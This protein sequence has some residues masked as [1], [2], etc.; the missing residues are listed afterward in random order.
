MRH[1]AAILFICSTALCFSQSRITV[2]RTDAPFHIDG[3]MDEAA[4][5]NAA[6]IADFIQRVPNSGEPMSERTEVYVTF[7]RDQLYFGLRC[8]DAQP[9][10][11]IAKQLA[12]DASLDYDDKI[13]III[14]TFLDRRSGYW[15]QIN[16][17]GCIGD[18][19][20]SQNG[21]AFNKSWDGL[22]EGAAHITA[23]GWEGEIAIPFKTMSFRKGQS[24][25]G[26][27]LIRQVSRK[28]EQGYWPVANLNSHKF[29]VSDAGL[30]DGLLDISQGIGLDAVPYAL[31][32][33]DARQGYERDYP[34]DIGLDAFYQIT[35]GLKSALT[36]NTDFAQTE[37]DDQRINL[38]RFPLFFEEKRDFFLDG[39]NYF[40]YGIDGERDHPYQTSLMPFFSRRLGLDDDGE[41]VPIIAGLKLTGQAGAWN[42]GLLDIVED[43]DGRASNA[44]VGRIARHIGGQ[45]YIGAIGT[46]RNSFTQAGNSLFGLDAKLATS[47]FLGDKNISLTL[48]GL[49]SD[50]D[51]S[52]GR[53]H[54]YGVS[55]IYPNDFIWIVTGWH[56]IGENF[57]AGLGFVPRHGI[58]RGYFRGGIGPRPGKWGILQ[59]ITG[60]H[61]NHV[62]DLRNV[63]LT[64]EAG[65]MPFSIEFLSGEHVE[66]SFY[67]TC[68][69]LREDFPIHPDHTIPVGDYQFWRSTLQGTTA[70][71][72]PFYFSAL[73]EAGGF[74]D[75]ARTQM[76]T[77][78]S[79]KV[80]VP[81]LVSM[82]YEHND[83]SLPSG[84][85]STD[86]GRLSVNVLFSP[87]VFLYNFIQYDNLSK[88]LG[89]QSRFVWI[90]KPGRE[91]FLVWK[92]I[93]QNP[94]DRFAMTESATRLKFK[95]TIRF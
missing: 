23:W 22:W 87:D 51:D 34:S 64:R 80:G 54:A 60:I 9:K 77:E 76:Q 92:S 53:D 71:R 66:F 63:L 16:P 41:L 28:S 2:P 57:N 25:W 75:G 48:H 50:T 81:L 12:R 27:K 88:K 40:N 24:S 74:F 8:Y 73:I 31:V 29:Q 52:T 17:R 44:A 84:D 11:I 14:D 32:G 82:E 18:A 78:M 49:R 37:V 91:L 39:S 62:T 86:V 59:S 47:T 33:A 26:L 90:L 94:F 4:W 20:V 3:R 43:Q 45:S 83:V 72:R 36:I 55:L 5:Q 68:E 46:V 35:P 69:S 1:Q 42:M 21:A 30:L 65:L 89:W 13:Q 7:A 6:V 70:Q 15:F 61:M 93:S 79:W 19:L 67:H 85:F 56:E 38:T 10:G 95:Y 58:R